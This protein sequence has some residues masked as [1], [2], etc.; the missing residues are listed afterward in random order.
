MPTKYRAGVIGRTGQ[1]NY[2]HGLDRVWNDL[3]EV[4]VVA[5]ADTDATG[6]AAARSRSGARREYADFRE[7]LEKERLDLVSVAPRWPDC[8][9]E[10]VI[11]AVEAGARGIFCEKP[12]A[13]TLAEA[14]AMLAAADQAGAKI[15]VGLQHRVMKVAQEM[16][17]IVESGELGEI[18]EVRGRPT[19][20]PRGGSFL[21]TVLGTH[22]LDLMRYFAGD[23]DWAFGR[24]TTREGREVNADDAREAAEG[25]GLL[26]GDAVGAIYGFA[27][28]VTGYCDSY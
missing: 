10:M 23:P 3:A 2:G 15:T 4:E 20:G 24:V 6:R 16:R 11:A 9:A 13:N 21:L 12:F 18:R 7:M 27:N 14:D 25:Y 22:V 17:R 19:I 1:G 5:V 8:H 28:G 26:A